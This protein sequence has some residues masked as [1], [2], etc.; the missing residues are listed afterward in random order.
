MSTALFFSSFRT[1]LPDQAEIKRCSHKRAL[2]LW[3]WHFERQICCEALKA[4][5]EKYLSILSPAVRAFVQSVE[6][7]AGVQ[8]TVAEDAELNN[9]GT[10]GQGIL[11]VAIEADCVLLGAPTNGYFPEGA[12]RHELL[13][14]RRLLVEKVPRLVLAGH[15]N[16]NELLEIALTGLDN[17]LEHLVIVPEE[18]EAHPERREHW[19]AIVARVWSS[20]IPLAFNQLDQRISAL[21]QWAFLAHVLPDSPRRALAEKFL[22]SHGWR[23]DAQNFTTELLSRL[24]DKTAVVATVFTAFPELPRADVELEYIE[25]G[26]YRQAPLP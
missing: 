9:R 22:D 13:H 6:A 15:A 24:S 25:S 3:D 11:R 21:T 5:Q 1:R 20:D 16:L 19:E 10:H 7:D 12:V 17:E 18:L 4:M 2:K 26:G 23:Q 14:V 8:V